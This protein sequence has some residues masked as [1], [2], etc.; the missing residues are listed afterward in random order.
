VRSVSSATR[1]PGRY[2]LRWDGKDNAGK[3]V[4]AG[5]YTVY[6]E[7]AREHGTH[8]M[9]KKEFDF[10][11]TPDKQTFPPNIEVASATFDYHKSG[12]K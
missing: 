7:V 9:V 2:S 11:G 10:N 5:R 1:G 6:L 12:G 8:Q 3:T 4:R